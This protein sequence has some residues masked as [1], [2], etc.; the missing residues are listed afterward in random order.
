MTKM[1]ART[2]G[3]VA[4][5]AAAFL[6]TTTTAHADIGGV[7]SQI[8]GGATDGSINPLDSNNKLV[9]TTTNDAAS[10][11]IGAVTYTPTGGGTATFS[12]PGAAPVADA[13]SQAVRANL[14]SQYNNV[15]TQ[16]SNTSQ[17]ASFNGINLLNGDTQAD[18]QR[19]RQVHAQHHRGHLQCQRSRPGQL[20]RGHGLP[21]QQLGQ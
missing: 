11:T 7:L 17:D 20:D 8:A 10:S 16:I 19:N 13:A 3:R 5:C 9:I 2:F 21:G 15:I 6:W 4:F 18:L 1:T 12:T 14:E